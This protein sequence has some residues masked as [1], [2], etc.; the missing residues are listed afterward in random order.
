MAALSAWVLLGSALG[1][2]ARYWLAIL[3]G[4]LL[5]PSFPWGTLLINV[6]GSMLIGA[7]G[8]AT[9]EREHAAFRA[10]VMVGVCGGFTTFSSFS[11]QTFELFQADRVAAALAY[12]GLSFG[13][14]LLAVWAGWAIGHAEWR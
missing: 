2:L 14:C 5:G 3:V 7:A 8:A 10:F 12:A 11:L 1:G 6:L 9:D 13:V 4:W